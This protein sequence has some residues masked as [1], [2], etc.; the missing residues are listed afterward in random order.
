MIHCVLPASN[1]PLDVHMNIL[2]HVL[3]I[4]HNLDFIKLGRMLSSNEDGS[5]HLWFKFHCSSGKKIFG[6]SNIKMSS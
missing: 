6:D 4:L 3:F 1:I 5:G 2:I